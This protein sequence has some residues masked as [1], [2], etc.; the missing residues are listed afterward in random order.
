M[1]HI[2][3]S[4]LAFLALAP[5]NHPVPAAPPVREAPEPMWL[6][7]YRQAYQL[8]EGEIVKR[9]PPPFCPERLEVHLARMAGKEPITEKFRQENAPIAPFCTLFVEQHGRELKP[10]M[11]LSSAYLRREPELQRGDHL[12]T[13]WTLVRTVTEREP[14]EIIIDPAA[15]ADPLFD[16]R[17]LTVSGDFV[18]RRETPLEKLAPPLERILHDECRTNA[19]LSLIEEVQDVFVVAGTFK[20]APPAWR[21]KPEIDVY[22]TE[23][24]LNK[25]YQFRSLD[26][27][28][29]NPEVLTSTGRGGPVALVRSLGER[30]QTRMVWD[31]PLPAEPRFY[32]HSHRRANPTQQQRDDDRDADKVLKH[33]A[34]QTGLTFRKER[35]KVTVLVVSAG[36]K[37]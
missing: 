16:E 18:I 15:N 3:M 35:R 17:N 25:D 12:L 20:L 31:A 6:A 5:L 11:I 33:V 27:A 13:V 1:S 14:P 26:P 19:R 32:W 21:Q 2:T 30:L 34:A 8:Q 28:R 36:E 9:V 4:A 23:E 10:P 37:K 29:E 22:A 24:G 7:N